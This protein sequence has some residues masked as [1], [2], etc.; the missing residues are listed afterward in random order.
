MFNNFSGCGHLKEIQAQ[1]PNDKPSLGF[2][3]CC[4]PRM[5]GRRAPVG[6]NI[7]AKSRPTVATGFPPFAVPPATFKFRPNTIAPKLSQH[8]QAPSPTPPPNLVALQGFAR[9]HTA[10]IT[11][12]LSN[13]R[14]PPFQRHNTFHPTPSA[15]PCRSELV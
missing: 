1:S 6:F 9:T 11:T 14:R 12:P 2:L 8:E 10:L 15:H 4:S 3:T 7:H 5:Q 13:H